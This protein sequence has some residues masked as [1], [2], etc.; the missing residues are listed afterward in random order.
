MPVMDG[1][2][3]LEAFSQLKYEKQISVII[4]TS[5]IN[6]EDEEKSESFS[7]VKGFLSKPL[8]SE[9]LDEVEKML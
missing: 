7:V 1:W 3:F 5:S 8:T 2:E 6:P 9:K 4:L